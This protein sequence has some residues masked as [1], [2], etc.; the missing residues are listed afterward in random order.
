MNSSRLMLVLGTLLLCSCGGSGNTETHALGGMVSGLVGSRLVL[1][2]NSVNSGK[3]ITPAGNG[4]YSDLFGNLPKGTAYNITVDTQ[5]T[6]P[7][8][9]CVVEN[10][11]GTISDSDVTNI[12]VTCT[13]NPGRFLYAVLGNGSVSGY[14]IDATSGA[15]TLVTGSPWTLAPLS[16]SFSPV[17]PVTIATDPT[18]KRVFVMSQ[19]NVIGGQLSVFDIDRGSG[20]VTPYD[21]VHLHSPNSTASE[22]GPPLSLVVHPS[23][24]FLYVNSAL[25]GGVHDTCEYSL[26]EYDVEH[27]SL[28]RF[29]G[30]PWDSLEPFHLVIDPVGRF[31][32]VNGTGGTHVLRINPDTG[33]LA[34]IPGSPFEQGELITD[35]APS[36]KFLYA[37]VESSTTISVYAVDGNTGALSTAPGSSL[38][39][40]PPGSPYNP[41]SPSLVGFTIDPRGQ[42]AYATQNDLDSI[43]IY[44]IEPSTGALNPIA[45]S[46]FP[47]TSTPNIFPDRMAVDPLGHAVYVTTISGP[48]GLYGG[49]AYTLDQSSGALTSPVDGSPLTWPAPASAIA[50]SN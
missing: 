17:E 48:P 12:H 2:T 38:Y 44:A 15:L 19:A 42:F 47:I 36:G 3:V 39:L 16:G 50:I 34:E 45:G 18:G 49:S 40:V 43:S 46:P 22:S 8:Q 25:C 27:R 11:S 5:P 24:K 20:A 10:G 31:L 21:N 32:Y 13:T 28:T 26:F 14:Q 6:N 30:V 23:G 4:S 41:N 35:A 29:E 9:T 7:S 33:D 37:A 1:Q